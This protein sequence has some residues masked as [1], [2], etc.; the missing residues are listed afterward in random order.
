MENGFYS[1]L[2]QIP[3]VSVLDLYAILYIWEAGDI[4][5]PFIYTSASKLV[6]FMY[7]FDKGKPIGSAYYLTQW[8]A[9]EIV[10]LNWMYNIR[11]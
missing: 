9:Q 6:S 8:F 1:L 5:L 2:A 4:F 11:P 10:K 7:R 3:F